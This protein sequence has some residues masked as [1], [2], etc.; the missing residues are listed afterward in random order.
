MSLR[1]SVYSQPINS[2]FVPLPP[3]QLILNPSAYPSLI[4]HQN[5]ASVPYIAAY[6][7][8][9]AVHENVV[10]FSESATQAP[11]T[12]PT[13]LSQM[14]K[15][16]PK[17][18]A[19]NPNKTKQTKR[20]STRVSYKK[21]RKTT[22]NGKKRN[23]YKKVTHKRAKRHSSSSV[24]YTPFMTTKNGVTLYLRNKKKKTNKQYSHNFGYSYDP[25]TSYPMSFGSFYY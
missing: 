12:Q 25:Y 16:A 18:I 22:I 17:M 21:V 14:R 6:H 7:N 10:E 8:P 4:A 9:S 3:E 19:R 20:S 23:L 11:P 5:P 15:I 2:T 24:K 13:R 1:Q